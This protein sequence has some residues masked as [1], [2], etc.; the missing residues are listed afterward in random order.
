MSNVDENRFAFLG[1]L[2]LP[3]F[4]I[5]CSVYTYT[6]VYTVHAVYREEKETLLCQFIH[7]YFHILVQYTY[8][9]DLD[10]FLALH[11]VQA[12]YLLYLS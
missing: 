7:K 3:V 9:A 8:R 11:F 10:P 12:I 6:S 4:F 1:T 2:I 5:V